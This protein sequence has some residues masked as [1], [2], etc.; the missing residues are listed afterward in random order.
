MKVNS[1]S[2]RYAILHSCYTHVPISVIHINNSILGIL[3]NEMVYF[4]FYFLCCTI[5]SFSWFL[6]FLLPQKKSLFFILQKWK[7]SSRGSVSQ[8]ATKNLCITFHRSS[9]DSDWDVDCGVRLCHS[10][11]AAAVATPGAERDFPQVK[12]SNASLLFLLL[13]FHCISF[14]FWKASKRD[15]D[16]GFGCC[17]REWRTAVG[18]EVHQQQK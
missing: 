11:G 3:L 1:Y 16:G 14:C 10:V 7:S 2:K 18:L 9:S 15:D 13:S 4:L 17:G 5:Q 12:L 8:K 6:L